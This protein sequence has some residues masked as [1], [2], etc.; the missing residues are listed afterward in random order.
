MKSPIADM[1]NTGVRYGGA[2]TAALFLRQFV[3]TDKVCVPRTPAQLRTTA[4]CCDTHCLDLCWSPMKAGKH[5][6]LGM[7]GPLRLAR[8]SLCQQHTHAHC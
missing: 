6:T 2:I 4:A 8:V 1:K 5:G 7:L 3:D